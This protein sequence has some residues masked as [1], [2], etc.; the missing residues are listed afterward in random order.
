MLQKFFEPSSV[1]VIGAS[2]R[3]GKVG[4]DILRNM[5]SSGFEGAVYPVNPRAAEILGVKC[6]PSVS[7]INGPVDLAVVVVPAPVVVPVVEECGAKG[8][9]AAVV[10]SAG[11]KE[12]G[13]EGV[14][15]ER[16]LAETAH[17]LGIRVIGPN[18]LGVMATG[19]GLNTT[20][21]VGFPKRGTVSLM[22]QSGALATAIIDWS[23]QHG[24]GYS[25]FVSFG[26]GVDV[27]VVDLLRAWE[28]DPETTV[29]VGYVEGLPN[30]PEFMDVARRVCA[31]KPVVV[32][33]SGST[34]AGA[35]AVSSHTGSLAGSEQAYEAAFLQS[36][37][38]RAHSMEELFDLAVAFAYQQVPRGARVGIVTNAG[39]PGIMATDAVERADLELAG[40]DPSTVA[41][42]HTRLPEAAN[43]YNPVDV[44]GD[45]EAD[46]YTFGAETL[47]ADPNVDAVVAVVTPQAMTEPHETAKG[48]ARAASASDKPVLSC[49]MGGQAMAEAMEYLNSRQ[50]PNYL[51]PERAVQALAAMVG[52]GR[53][54]EEPPDDPPSF[55]FDE[56]AVRPIFARAR[57]EGRVNL[58]EIEAREVLRAYHIKV[59]ESRVAETA[60]QAEKH[61][62]EIGFPV[63]MKII[64]PDILHKSDIGGVRVG[65]RDRQQAIDAYDLMMLRV[66]R[67]APNAALRGVAV[68]QMIQGGREVIIGSTRDPQF[69]PLVMFGLGGIY[70]EVLND[71]SFRVAPFGERHAR[72]MIE[73][74]RSAP[75]LHG[76][77]GESPCDIDAIVHSL[78]VVSQMVT[79]LPE[80]VE[81]D[82]NPLRVGDPGAGVV[83]L[84]ARITIAE[85]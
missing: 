73:E 29:I 6:Y 53:W 36:G 37:V 65:I 63:V 9:E 12:A 67:Y 39:G 22:S 14:E 3:P 80:I 58:G 57:A 10:I 11:F 21:A 38:I 2:T 48:L 76:A 74:I 24:V 75:L 1:A 46:R 23:I 84:D 68:Q 25:K 5:L 61:A 19:N 27:G 7:E 60:E 26:N 44:L 55:P 15:R 72:R 78:L 77:R 35:R 32:M 71:V 34:Q 59:P 17:R 45:A 28:D 20:F 13:P 31:K 30:G 41:T 43:F 16:Q 52:Y 4:H 47:L 83:A 18:C 85:E 79:D 66:R 49:F 51:F 62:S 40:L 50:V 64:S 8:V 56:Q 82:V 54:R 70:V 42:L 69:G 81:M 33:K